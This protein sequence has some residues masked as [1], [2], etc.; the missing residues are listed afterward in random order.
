VREPAAR[1]HQRPYKAFLGP[2]GPQQLA[3]LKVERQSPQEA[4]RSP[5]YVLPDRG[6]RVKPHRLGALYGALVR[7]AAKSK[8][9]VFA[10]TVSM[11]AMLLPSFVVRGAEL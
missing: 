4:A 6:T 11:S 10:S 3:A 9:R 8:M 1:I 5:A 7:V 2:N